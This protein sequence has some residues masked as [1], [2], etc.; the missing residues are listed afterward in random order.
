MFSGLG[1][2]PARAPGVGARAHIDCCTHRM[3]LGAA[4]QT[5]CK[6][7]KALA[8]NSATQS[9]FAARLGTRAE[10]AE[11]LDSLQQVRIRP[12]R[13]H[14]ACWTIVSRHNT[15]TEMPRA[16]RT[17]PSPTRTGCSPVRAVRRVWAQRS[18]PGVNGAIL[19][20][21]RWKWS[22]GIVIRPLDTRTLNVAPACAAQISLCAPAQ[23]R[24]GCSKAPLR[25][26]IGQVRGRHAAWRRIRRC[27]GRV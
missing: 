2:A 25:A 1:G 22:S 14:L 21:T 8:R 24:H 19:T 12:R 7:S 9:R 18:I 3:T 23:H 17:P 5:A 11:A 4:F 13:R 20:E 27:S 15:T 10:A 16:C 26:R 6:N